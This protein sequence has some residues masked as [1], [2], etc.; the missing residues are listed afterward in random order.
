MFGIFNKSKKI[1]KALSESESLFI[2][3]I[4][5][6][7]E[8]KYPLFK[9][10]FDIGTFAWVAPNKIGGERSF[11]FGINSDAWNKL[12]DTTCKNYLIKNIQFHNSA[13]KSVIVDLY[14]TEGLIVGFE[15]SD[16]I[17]NIDL[18]S[19]NISNIWEKYFL[20]SDSS[21]IKSILGNLNKLQLRQLNMIANTFKIEVDGKCY[22]PI[23]DIGDGNYFAVDN[24][25]F[26]FKITHDPFFAQFI[27]ET[28]LEFLQILS[29]PQSL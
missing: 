3:V 13:N 17:V 24:K 21:E 20:D 29:D 26:V 10:E 8:S 15:A 11:V 7:L 19:I 12:C 25:G 18:S 14:T 4:V 27:C 2:K 22:Y 6:A 1:S 5:Q 16:D 28:V 23:H 9:Q